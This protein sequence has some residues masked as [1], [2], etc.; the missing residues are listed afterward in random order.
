LVENSFKEAMD[1]A[2]RA[3]LPLFLY[4][5]E[6]K[7]SLKAALE[8]AIAKLPDNIS[9]IAC[10][11]KP[12]VSIVTGP[13]GG[14]EP[15]EAEIARNAGLLTVSLGSRILRCET[16]PIAALAIVMFFLGEM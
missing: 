8:Q 4:E 6:S 5:S 16:A 10:Q 9:D 14:F 7:L 1:R 12:T 13:E 3:S 15:Y 11:G 2:S